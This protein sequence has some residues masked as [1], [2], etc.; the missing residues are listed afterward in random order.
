MK[1][2]KSLGKAL[3]NPLRSWTHSIVPR[4]IPPEIANTASCC[5][6]PGLEYVECW[7]FIYCVLVSFDV[8]YKT[9]YIVSTHLEAIKI[10]GSGLSSSKSGG[11]IICLR[12]GSLYECNCVTL[13]RLVEETTTLDDSKLRVCFLFD[14]NVNDDT[15]WIHR[16]I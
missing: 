8:M 9:I 14:W 10:D 6:G 11:G 16:P 13:F 1:Q 3:S 15:T 2:E 12:G 7:D 4:T 5:S